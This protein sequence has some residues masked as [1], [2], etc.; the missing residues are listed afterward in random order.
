MKKFHLYNSVLLVCQYSNNQYQWKMAA[1]YELANPTHSARNPLV[2][3]AS[4]C[5]SV[6]PI[7]LC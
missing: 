6:V 3:I 2:L 1:W 5:S 4:M 7:P